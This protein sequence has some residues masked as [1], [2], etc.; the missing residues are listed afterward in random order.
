MKKYFYNAFA[1]IL[2]KEWSPD[3]IQKYVGDYH[4]CYFTYATDEVFRKNAA[5]GGSITALLAYLLQSGRIDGALVCRT[6]I[7]NNSVTPEFF[8]ARTVEDLISAQGSKY[9]A[10]YFP[11]QAFPLIQRFDGRLAVVA[12][13]CDTGIVERKRKN[14]QEFRDKVVVKISMF[15]GHNSEPALI[16]KIIQ[17][18]NPEEKGLVD[19]RFRLG[20]WR[21]SL[22]AKFDNGKT[23]TKPF[24]YF[25]DYQNLYFFSQ[26]KCHH[27]HD[28]TGYYADIS[29]GDIWSLRMKQEPI[30]HTALI[31]RSDIGEEFVRAALDNGMLTGQVEPIAEVCEGQARTMPFHYNLTAR[32]RLSWLSGEKI[33]DTVN[34]H[35]R[36]NDLIVAALILLNERFSR[37]KAG[38]KIIFL[39]PRPLMKLYLYFIKFLESF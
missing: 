21:G 3:L 13:P 8:I 38:R 11:S 10:V 25:S 31:T 37:S 15:C 35:V 5:S 14:S 19:Y 36:W 28:H 9:S 27:C 34:E 12:L 18:L 26:R 16:E 17:R 39:I 4:Q 33:K 1:R 30:K 32:S 7:E 23:V 24:S 6:R 2:R 22:Q 20:H 29:A